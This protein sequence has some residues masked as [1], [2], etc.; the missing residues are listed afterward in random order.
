M[1]KI[2]KNNMKKILKIILIVLIIILV[3]T[4]GENIK[5][6]VKEN[7]LDLNI[8][9][10][11]DTIKITEKNNI[12]ETEVTNSEDILINPGKGLVL[13]SS[14]PEQVNN[15]ISVHYSRFKWTDIEPEKGRYD[16]KQIDEKLEYCEKNG[17]KFAFGIVNASTAYDG[18]YVTPKWVFDEGA[19]YYIYKKD[20]LDQIVP[21]WTDEIFLR[22]LNGFIEKLAER[23]DGNETIEYIDIRSYGNY[24]E[25]HL[26]TIGGE[27]IS[28]KQL[29]E[30]YIK[31]YMN[32]FK[33]T[34]LIN[35]WG[36]YN[37][38]GIY[39]W[40]IDNG[41]SIRR[42][43]IM[44][45]TN[46]KNIFEYAYRKLPTIFEFYSKYETLKEQGLWSEEELLKYV[47]EWKPSYVEYWPEM[48]RDNP[49][50][51]KYLGNRIGY[52][53]KL[54]GT[55]YINKSEI[56]KELNIKM[57]FSNE[58][59]APLY[60]NCSVYIGLLDENYNLIQKYKTDVDPKTWLP[61][62]PIQENVK[63]ILNNI[64]PGKY[65]ISIGLFLN[66]NDEHP[67]YLLGNAGKT[68]DRWYV[69]GYIQIEENIESEIINKYSELQNSYLEN[70][71]LVQKI[72]EVKQYLK[73]IADSS[74]IANQKQIEDLISM[75]YSIVDILIQQDSKD[76]REFV[77]KIDE[78]GALY[79]R[80]FEL[81]ATEEIFG[82][83]ILDEKISN[84]ENIIKF[85]E[86][87]LE[88]SNEIFLF[89]LAK[90]RYDEDSV[91]G[92]FQCENLVNIVNNL[93]ET[94]A[95]KYNLSSLMIEYSTNELTNQDVVVKL[96]SSSD[97]IEMPYGNTYT[98]EKNGTFIFRYVYKGNEKEI[99]AT[100]D[101]IDKQAPIISGIDNRTD[102]TEVATINVFDKNLD[103][104]VVTKDGQ[105]IPFN[106]G[107]TLFEVGNYVITATDKAG[108][109]TIS[110]LRVI[111][112]VE[113]NKIY[114]ISPD[115]TG[116]GLFQNKPMNVATAST[117]K[118]NAGDKILFK[119]GEKY[120]ID[121]NWNMMGSP[122]NAITIS[123]FG[124][125]DLPII[126]G[127]IELVSNLH[128]YN[129]E[130]TNNDESCLIT[131]QSYTENVAISNCI[132]NNIDDTAV[133]LNKQISNIKI[134]NC[135]FK[136]CDDSGIAVKNDDKALR[137]KDIFINDNIF[138][139][140]NNALD[141]SGENE[142][143]EFE[144]LHVHDNYFVNCDDIIS[145]GNIVE[146]K[147]DVKFFNNLYYNFENLY[148][149]EANEI[150]NLKSNLVS[151]NNTFY[152]LDGFEFLD[153]C[154]DF[155]R[156]KDEYD[157]EKNS[158]FV[159]MNED[160]QVELVEEI[161]KNSTNK[162]EI[163]S[164]LF[165]TIRASTL[166]KKVQE[167]HTES[168]LVIA[169][170]G[171][172]SLIS[173]KIGSADELEAKN[174]GEEIQDDTTSPDEL[175]LAGLEKIAFGLILIIFINIALSGTNYCKYKMH[176]RKQIKK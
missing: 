82:I 54:K 1:G 154:E 78:I 90:E 84:T 140:L 137:G 6:N 40:A 164:Y 41:I 170:S 114:Y 32:N 92:Y 141:I 59:V 3:I 94:K 14:Y 119:S 16:W 28:S 118:Y 128:I 102:E 156:L 10:P 70:K 172:D 173:S 85:Y 77:E 13:R 34:R 24:G 168:G 74:L 174:N 106:N 65:I 163:I 126:N 57:N 76:L 111:D 7:G 116:N 50:F 60:E 72:E 98:F 142:L 33:K 117:L 135:V 169:S 46:G 171:Y 8:S 162:T 19:Q 132:F 55:Q 43:G 2:I 48:Y 165:E 122:D 175:P 29:K 157:L 150:Q 108:N 159:I 97:E 15:E 144:R 129:L 91:I 149:V 63:I 87:K 89:D 107:D 120:N 75:N 105:V 104:I 93:I 27:N 148:D 133:Y 20:G 31:P 115:G 145:L 153:G 35:P 88:L 121:L 37:Y 151:D 66:D 81:N 53:F 139:N 62:K 95:D 101:W 67:T 36:D 51:V 143:Q 73:S 83:D 4:I 21:V 18:K 161:C 127:S 11:I 167:V 134:D 103:S 160:Y 17:K 79:Y 69:F 25:Q 39:E 12:V 100:V 96:I 130:F 110:E 47:D 49:E 176:I 152:V 56:R 42:D 5:E 109:V 158:K 26:F 113:S 45:Y 155:E 44:K 61:D 166:N 64:N 146:G 71:A 147:F 23:Y 68:D 38:N 112:F 22:E 125:G 136:N 123:S 131:N 99:I 80:L 52:Y 30:L 124:D 138:I 58:G 9:N 86:E